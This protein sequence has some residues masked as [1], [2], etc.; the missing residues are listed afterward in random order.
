M[1]ELITKYLTDKISEE[2]LNQL[3]LWLK[4]PANQQYFK[5]MV[6]LNYELDQAYRYI[7][8][9][10]AFQNIF[11]HKQPSSG[12]TFKLYRYAA[13]IALIIGLSIGV[14]TLFNIT[15]QTSSTLLV[16]NEQPISLELE[17]GSFIEIDHRGSSIITNSD[18]KKIATLENGKLVYRSELQSNHDD[19]LHRLT[20]PFGK[21]FELQLADGSEIKL[22]SGTTIAFP[23][24]FNK[25][26]QRN[27]FLNGEA[28]FSVE[29]DENH[30]FV[31]H[32]EHMNI[33]VLGTRFNVS[34]YG[35][36]ELTST[37]LEEGS[38]AVYR[39][40]VDYKEEASLVLS[41]GQQA[42][43]EKEIFQLST[44]DTEKQLAW[45]S[46]Q[47]FFENDRFEDI[48]KKLER[49]YNVPLE[50]SSPEL[51][52]V[53]YTGTFTTETLEQVLEAF[54]KNTD[55]EYL[56]DDNKIMIKPTFNNVRSQEN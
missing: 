28:Y 43:I 56:V 12:R 42:V 39:P 45:T 10:T 36:E 24:T 31:V 30:P 40:A 29:K 19:G 14:F 8:T 22:N 48:I 41:P 52:D 23:P 55:F 34:S 27:V 13:T 17:D 6:Q 4:K 16:I 5:Q 11:R 38:V 2:E 37:V 25:M 32:T 26:Q 1:D 44:A 54:K 49:Y 35:N 15:T 21:R 33:R 9:D 47:L 7:D 53:R 46:G 18:G 20:I 50:I 3:T 51:N